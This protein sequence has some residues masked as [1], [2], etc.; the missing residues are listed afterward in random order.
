[1][2]FCHLCTFKAT[3]RQMVHTGVIYIWDCSQYL[4]CVYLIKCRLSGNFICN[5]KDFRFAK[6]TMAAKDTHGDPTY[7]KDVAEGESSMLLNLITGISWTF[8]CDP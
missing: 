1:M 5:S 3:E 8:H 2:N 4:S 6:A 7:I